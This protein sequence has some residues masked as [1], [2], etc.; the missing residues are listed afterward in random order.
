MGQY[1]SIKVIAKAKEGK[2]MEL[3]GKTGEFVS[4]R[5]RIDDKCLGKILSQNTTEGLIES[6]FGPFEANPEDAHW[7]DGEWLAGFH[8][9][10]GWE[11][12]MYETFEAM[13]PYLE[14]G[15]KLICRC[16]SPSWTLIVSDDGL[17]I[18]Q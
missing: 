8:G 16:E 7:K 10:Y 9:S 1:Y 11:P 5:G 4:N 13:A 18:E 6:I 3:I 2:E 15:S 17:A 14:A 12:F